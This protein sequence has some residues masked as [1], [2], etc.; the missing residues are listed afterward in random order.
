[1]FA[2]IAVGATLVSLLAG[3]Q[4]VNGVCLDPQQELRPNTRHM[5]VLGRWVD[6]LD[7][8]A[9]NLQEEMFDHDTYGDL[10]HAMQ[11]YAVDEQPT[12]C[13]SWG[14]TPDCDAEEIADILTPHGYDAANGDIVT[15]LYNSSTVEWGKTVSN[16]VMVQPD[17]HRTTVVH[18]YGHAIGGLWHEHGYGPNT[19]EPEGDAPNCAPSED[20]CYDQWG[21]LPGVECVQGC[22]EYAGWWRAYS[23]CVMNYDSIEVAHDAYCQVCDG[24]IKEALE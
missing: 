13:T 2:R 5:F 15:V 3:C 21:N 1:M 16:V 22:G 24:L 17:W 20:A 7:G 6:D 19:G 10:T 9:C 14:G 8:A 12:L 18:E 11:F 4:P 23:D